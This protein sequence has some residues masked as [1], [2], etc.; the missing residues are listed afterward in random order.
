MRSRTIRRTIVRGGLH[1]YEAVYDRH[2]QLGEHQHES[3]FFTYVLRGE[4][5]EAVGQSARQCVRG[6]VIFH[7]QREVHSNSVGQDGTASLNVEIPAEQWTELTADVVRN[8]HLVGRVLSGDV[9]W[10]ALA[11]WREFHHDDGASVIGLSESVAL[12]CWQLIESYARGSYEPH[13]RLDRCVEYLRAH[14]GQT[15][16]LTD[17]ARIAEVHPMH[18]AKLFRKR[19]GYSMGEYVRRQRIAWACD[20]L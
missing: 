12:L 15:P 1:T 18:L 5:I 14:R 4:Y 9:E 16:T 6:A 3:P 20:Q 10:P 8:Q 11:V 7:Y 13:A 2:A 17:V 19:F